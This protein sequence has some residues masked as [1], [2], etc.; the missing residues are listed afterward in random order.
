MRNYYAG[1]G[2]RRTPAGSHQVPESLVHRFQGL[3]LYREANGELV[4]GSLGTIRSHQHLLSPLSEDEI[5]VRGLN[6]RDS[7]LSILQRLIRKTEGSPD[8]R[9]P[10]WGEMGIVRVTGTCTQDTQK[11]TPRPHLIL[12]PGSL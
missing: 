12:S 9:S 6:L 8:L 3:D 2:S 10:F 1:W 4:E 11:I 5:E 7:S